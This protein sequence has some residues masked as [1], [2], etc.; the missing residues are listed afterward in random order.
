MGPGGARRG[1][2][3]PDLA[4]R[5]GGRGPELLDNAPFQATPTP[6]APP[7]TPMISRSPR[8]YNLEPRRPC[9]RYFLSGGLTSGCVFPARRLGSLEIDV[10]RGAEHVFYRKGLASAF[11]E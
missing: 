10:R 6:R 1:E 5:D 4:V 9:P 2:P 7:R 8:S 3:E 11:C